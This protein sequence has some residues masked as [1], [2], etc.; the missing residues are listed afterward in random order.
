[1][2]DL[3]P[4]RPMGK[5]S[6]GELL[7]IPFLDTDTTKD[8]VLANAE[9]QLRGYPMWLISLLRK[10]CGVGLWQQSFLWE[11][12]HL[13]LAD[14]AAGYG[15]PLALLGTVVAVLANVRHPSVAWVGLGMLAF[16]L[17]LLIAAVLGW[18]H[19]RKRWAK[20]LAEGVK[21]NEP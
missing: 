7:C 4:L 9:L 21:R 3:D 8:T 11:N 14:V 17:T 16:G 2:R 20:S 10:L 15:L 1:M 18:R 5:L 19:S 6:T 12:F 13:D